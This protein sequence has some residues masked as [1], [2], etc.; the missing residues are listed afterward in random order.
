M[1]VE[2]ILE[3]LVGKTLEQSMMEVME[4]EELQNMRAHQEHFEQIRNAELAETQRLE[5]YTG[6]P[7]YLQREDC[8]IGV[9]ESFYVVHTGGRV[10]V[11]DEAKRKLEPAQ[12][13]V[14]TSEGSIVLL[15]ALQALAEEIE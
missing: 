14:G 11:M 4:E 3:V 9:M 10:S 1:E 13:G 5:A 6:A 8:V 7:S 2:P 15:R 12:L